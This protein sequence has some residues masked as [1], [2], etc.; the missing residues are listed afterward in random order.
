MLSIAASP[1]T[2]DYVERLSQNWFVKVR[3]GFQKH[4]SSAKGSSSLFHAFAFLE[5]GRDKGGCCREIE[6]AAV[7]MR[8]GNKSQPAHLQ[9]LSG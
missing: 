1:S 3:Y 9:G 6:R 4:T 2:E 7:A 8:W 5:Y